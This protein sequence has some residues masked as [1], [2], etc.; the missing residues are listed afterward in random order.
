MKKHL[1]ALVAIALFFSFSPAQQVRSVWNSKKSNDDKYA[2]IKDMNKL[3]I[4]DALAVAK[5]KFE[6]RKNP[7]IKKAVSN[8]EA[9]LPSQKAD[10]E[11]TF[12]GI[13]G[14]YENYASENEMKLFRVYGPN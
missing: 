3:S 14:W 10:L 4:A 5:I 6:A 9:L 1:L 7:F 2:S 13:N 12:P 11:K 8:Y